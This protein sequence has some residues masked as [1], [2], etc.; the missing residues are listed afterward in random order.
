LDDGAR[1]VAVT[2]LPLAAAVK[3]RR[4]ELGVSDLFEEVKCFCVGEIDKQ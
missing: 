2:L 1:R 3:R 4:P